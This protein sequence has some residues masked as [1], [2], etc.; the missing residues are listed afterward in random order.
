MATA[1][2]TPLRTQDSVGENWNPKRKTS[3]TKRS[4]HD[5]SSRR[6]LGE[7]KPPANKVRRTATYSKRK[8]KQKQKVYGHA[9]TSGGAA[10]RQRFAS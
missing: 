10:A 3:S 5:V 2:H 1:E 7:V 8:Q 4:I 9:A 6:A